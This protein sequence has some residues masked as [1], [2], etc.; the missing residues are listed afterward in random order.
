MHQLSSRQVLCAAS[1]LCDNKGS[2]HHLSRHGSRLSRG[3]AGESSDGNDGKKGNSC[4]QL[5]PAAGSI[6][7]PVGR[8][9]D[10]GKATNSKKD[11]L[12]VK[13]K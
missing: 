1:Q 7:V 12:Y 8:M 3:G 10:K 6:P 13:A 2:R 11:D 4:S 9:R 5:H